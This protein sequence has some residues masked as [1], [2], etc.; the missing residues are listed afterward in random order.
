MRHVLALCL[1]LLAAPAMPD[2]LIEDF[3]QPAGAEWRFFTDQVMG[4]VSTGMATIVE[5][6]R[7]ALRLTGQVSTENR[8]GFIQARKDLP[9]G[10]PEDAQALRITVRGDGQRYFLHLRTTGTMLPW[11]YYQAGFEAPQDWTELRV[12]L[13]AFA[14]SG[15]LLRQAVQPGAVRSVALVAYGRDHEARVELAR[16]V[17]E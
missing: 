16:I 3:A 1:S 2:T 8:G 5:E 13:S 15:R 12:P 9:E 14:P 4:G 10:L 17:A 7:P 11:Q 6:D